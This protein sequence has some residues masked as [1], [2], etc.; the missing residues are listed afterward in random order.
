VTVH[1]DDASPDDRLG[2]AD[3]QRL[4]QQAAAGDH[5][6]WERIYR[7]VYPRLRA[8]AS[9]HVGNDTA[10][11]VVSETMT[12]A[13]AG[14]EGFRWTPAGIEPWLFGI[15]RRVIADHHRR[16]GRLRRRSRAIAAPAA[17]LPADVAELADEHAAVRAAFSRLSD[18]DRELLELRIIA[19]LT[20]EQTAMAL[21]KRPGA[22]RAAQSRALARL[23]QRLQQGTAP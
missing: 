14:I 23:R 3:P 11:D 19:G 22:V 9:H 1:V 6:A 13:V 15:A 7:A 10:D 8:Y 18:G 21:G 16:A 2:S 17:P 4:V 12:R 20:P 5:A